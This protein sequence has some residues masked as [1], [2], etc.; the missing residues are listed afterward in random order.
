M[1]AAD[2]GK[3]AS[4]Q[5]PVHLVGRR[6]H[7]VPLQLHLAPVGACRLSG[8]AQVGRCRRCRGQGLAV[9]VEAIAQRGSAA[10]QSGAIDQESIGAHAV[11]SGVQRRPVDAAIGALV[12]AARAV[13]VPDAG[14]QRQ[15]ARPG[16][17]DVVDLLAS[18]ARELGP[19]DA[20]VQALPDAA[21]GVGVAQRVRVVHGGV[22]RKRRTRAAVDRQVIHKGALTGR[23]HRQQHAAPVLSIVRTAPQARLG[24]DQHGAARRLN[25]PD[26]EGVTAE[27]IVACDPAPRPRAGEVKARAVEA[28]VEACA[29]ARI[30]AQQHGLSGQI[31]R[32][33]AVDR[34]P[35]VAR[36]RVGVSALVR[37]CGVQPGRSVAREGGDDAKAGAADPGRRA[38]AGR[39]LE[40]AARSAHDD[41]AG[42]I[43]G[44]G[45]GPASGQARAGFEPGRAAV[46]ALVGTGLGGGKQ[47][48]H[49]TVVR[50]IGKED[51]PGI[52][53]RRLAGKL[54]PG[55]APVGRAV[56][57]T[58]VDRDV[59]VGSVIGDRRGR[60][61]AGGQ[62]AV[63]L[64][65]GRA[66]VGGTHQA[67]ALDQRQHHLGGGRRAVIGGAGVVGHVPVRPPVG[68]AAVGQLQLEQQRRAEL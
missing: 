42:G 45:H 43:E 36:R 10:Q 65:P 19:G 16:G 29:A 55:K 4:A 6:A 20:A 33:A 44:R 5:R 15:R 63:G 31:R 56:N 22:G 26:L 37:R 58:A 67:N 40:D 9:Q 1:R 54:R 11:Q 2:V 39:V 38:A 53:Q 68:D 12:D 3:R 57:A 17:P 14:I 32:Q 27:P 35:G 46:Q 61:R 13:L 62:S 25:V 18:Q 59:P 52:W 64:R 51:E 50:V 21:G 60:H 34:A 28:G 23:G 49:A 47:R 7:V 30:D 41:V 24:G 8:N 48:A 66:L